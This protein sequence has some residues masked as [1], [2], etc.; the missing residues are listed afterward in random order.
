VRIIF[1][2]KKQLSFLICLLSTFLISILNASAQTNAWNTSS[3]K[4]TKDTTT[5]ADMTSAANVAF[6][7]SPIVSSS[8]ISI[9]GFSFRFGLGTYNKFYISP[10]GFVKLGSNIISNNPENDSTVIVPLYNGTP[11]EASY[12]IVGFAPNRKMVIQYSGVM[13][14]TGEPTSFQIWLYERT[15]RIQFVYAHLRGFYGYGSTWNYKIFCATEV[16]NSNTIAYTKIKSNN[17][18][19]EI[20]YSAKS[21]SFDSIYAKTRFTFQPDTIKPARPS[22]LNFT[23]I[24]AGCVSVNITEH[25]NNE[26]VVALER[27]D[28]GT[29]YNIE[30]LYYPASATGNTVYNYSQSLLQPFWNYNYLAYV[31]NGF[32]NSDTLHNSVQTL[33]PQINGIKK[34]PGDYP[35]IT[36]LLQDAGCKHV[37]PNLIIELQNNY[38]FAS[39]TSP[40]TFGP[41]LQ[42]NFIQS[43]VVRPAANATVNWIDSTATALLYVDSVK[44]VFIDGRPGGTGTS[45]NLTIY[46]KNPLAAVIQYTN[47]ADSGGINYCKIIKKNSS[48]LKNAVV[49]VPLNNTFNRSKKD[50]NAFSIT[51]NFIS[52]DSETV[53]DL[54]YIN[55]SDTLQARDFI[56][57][58]NQFSR[59][60][61]SAV[62]FEN[63]GQNLQIKNNLFFQPITFRPEVYLPYTNASCLTLLNIGKVTID[64]NYFGGGS[65]TWGKGKFSIKS[66]GTDFCFINYQNNSIIKKAFITNNKFANIEFDGYS[67]NAAKLIYA[68]K[69]DVLINNNFFGT[70]DS[71]NSITSSSFFWGI[72]LNYGNKTVSNNFFSGFQGSYLTSGTSNYSYFI[73]SS[74]TDSCAFINN[75]IGGSNNPEA[76]SSTGM[77]H[78]IYLSATEKNV[79]IKNNVIRGILSKNLS[80]IAVSGANGLS[81]TSQIKLEIDS[82]SIH[83]IQSASSVTGIA[84]KVNSRA[85]NIISHNNIYAL[86]TTGTAGSYSPIGVLSG[87]SY[88]MY[89][90][91]YPPDQYKGEVRIFGNKIHGFEPIRMLSNSS[92][93]LGGIGVSS[94]VSKIYN[95]EISFGIDSKGQFIDSLTIVGGIGVGPVD[96]QTFLSDKHY[97]EH[98]SIYFGGKGMTGSA[99]SAQYSHN[100]TSDN[101]RVTITNNIL[102]IE[103]KPPSNDD[104]SPGMYQNTSA[105]IALSANN[106]W[107]SSTIPNTPALLQSYKQSCNCD[108]SSFIGDPVFINALGDSA[109]YNLHLG[110]SS[111][112][113]SRGTPSVLNISNDLNDINRNAYSPVDIGC[114]VA[115]PCGNGTFP[116]ITIINGDSDTIQ[117]C[118][119]RNVTLKSSIAGGSFTSLQWQHNLI[120]SA[121][122]IAD[123]LIVNSP[124]SYRIVGKTTCGL[125]ASRMIYCTNGPLQPSV[126]ISTKDTNICSGNAVTFTADVANGGISPSYQWQINGVNVGVN[127]DTFTTSAL[128][129]NDSVKVLLTYFSCTLPATIESNLI[130]VKVTSPPVANAGNDVTICAGATSQ[131]NASGGTTYSWSPIT[132]L[133]NANIANPIAS[134]STTTT[135]ILTVINGNSCSAKDSILITVNPQSMAPKVSI[136]TSDSS[137]CLGGIATFAASAS[138]GGTNPI[139]QWQVNSV[140]VGSNNNVFTSANFINNDR[141]DVILTSDANCLVNKIDTSNIITMDVKQLSVP[142]LMINDQVL[143]VINPDAEATYIWQIQDNGVWSDIIP[144]ATGNMYSAPATGT[145]RV[146]AIKGL[147]MNYSVSQVTN[148]VTRF[149]ANNPFGI[150]L[151]PNPA[152]K[153][154][155]LDSIN[156]AQHWETLTIADISGKQVLFPIDIKNKTSV[157]IDIS[158]LIK[159]VYIVKLR[160]S[161]GKSTT[162]KFIKQ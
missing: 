145:Y 142:T 12:K 70:S 52:A 34:I 130:S 91:G 126:S 2:P 1:F 76:N 144:L 64:G 41:S 22:M 84:L 111:K 109:N 143:S 32:V 17:A 99:I 128:K 4:F 107:Y 154:I 58:G 69:G 105:I 121:G 151:Y 156:I 46:Q 14:P 57:S 56:I 73:T 155:T 83:H 3:F 9:S 123:S 54:I 65:A 159:S 87:I 48:Y 19:P 137:I 124:G 13:Q 24:L 30:K 33:M 49:V 25:S 98:N 77:V 141:I 71:S 100:Y 45:Q 136:S 161:D 158:Y 89:N 152:L 149:P 44:H 28:N 88:S 55:P 133:N 97:I 147:C 113:D 53:S 72:D 42:N 160:T 108:S 94:P 150:Y 60:R 95:N 116:S 162:L 101:N 74:F 85:T 18:F 68:S 29:N 5:L 138:N 115:T 6:T 134:P 103:R 31:S 117:L 86:K 79:T 153:T 21:V 43:I 139:F 114:Y 92:F 7:G 51:N 122:A 146:K 61:R 120:D 118:G 78:G 96:Y 80:V 26:S 127:T 35:S 82:N 38:S 148:I 75:D 47:A 59:F 67:Q 90:Y 129:D 106:L 131:L 37:G 102:D 39:E 23:N 11:W 132:G 40:L 110:A 20:S 50:I 15:G 66:S 16:L 135:Y 36:A 63:G 10:Y 81:N 112:A 62:H 140:N 93:S 8:E 119:G 27:A 104:I 125:V 157:S